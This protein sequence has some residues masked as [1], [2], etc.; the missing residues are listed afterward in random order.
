MLSCRFEKRR[1]EYLA[2]QAGNGGENGRIGAA[3]L[4]AHQIGLIAKMRR[5]AFDFPG[6]QVRRFR[7]P[8]AGPSP[9]P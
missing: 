7:L 6:S 2:E 9:A 5:N 3:W 4:V 8:N 1:I